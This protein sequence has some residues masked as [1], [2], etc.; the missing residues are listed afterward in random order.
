M[1]ETSIFSTLSSSHRNN[2]IN[3][4]GS[5]CMRACVSVCVCACA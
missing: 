5:A 2:D 1:I 3:K 4:E